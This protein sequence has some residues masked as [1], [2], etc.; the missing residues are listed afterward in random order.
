[1]P[2]LVAHAGHWLLWVLYAVPVLIVVGSI[3]LSII[4]QRRE[5]TDVDGEAT[6]EP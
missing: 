1:V 2:Q 3:V 6:P 4:R 5:G